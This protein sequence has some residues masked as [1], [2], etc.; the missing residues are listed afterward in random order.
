[1]TINACLDELYAC[2]SGGKSILP[3]YKRNFLFIIS[4]KNFSQAILSAFLRLYD[5]QNS[6]HRQ[7]SLKNRILIIKQLQIKKSHQ[8]RK[9]VFLE[10]M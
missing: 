9:S 3:G 8:N 7:K 5:F 6:R 4:G 10:R 1:M 2:Q